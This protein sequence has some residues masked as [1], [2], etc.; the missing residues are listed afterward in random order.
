MV[1]TQTNHA[2]VAG[3]CA[4]RGATAAGVLLLALAL[5]AGG[6]LGAG[7][8]APLFTVLHCYSCDTSGDK[9][10]EEQD[11]EQSS[12]ESEA[13]DSKLERE[14]E[15]LSVAC[16]DCSVEAHATGVASCNT[17]SSTPF[18]YVWN[19]NEY[20]VDNDVLLAPGTFHATFAA[21]ASAYRQKHTFDTYLLRETP[22]V[23]EG[24]LKLA[25]KEIEPEETHLDT[26]ALTRL[27][28]PNNMLLCETPLRDD[29]QLF[30]KNELEA[31]RGVSSVAVQTGE[32]GQSAVG[33]QVTS[34]HEVTLE[35]GQV[36]E[37][38]GIVENAALH[39]TPYLLLRSRYRD[40]AAGR[41]EAFEEEARP[42]P[43]SNMAR[44]QGTGVRAAA[45]ALLAPF[46]W[47]ANTGTAPQ[48]APNDPAFLASH[49][50]TTA[51]AAVPA[52][53]GCGCSASNDE[54]SLV[55]EYFNP[56]DGRW[57][58]AVIVQPR[59]HH[60]VLEAVPLPAAAVN[61]A[62]GAVRVRV[63]ATK[64]HVVDILSLFVPSYVGTK[65]NV[66]ATPLSLTGATH[67]RLGAVGTLGGR[68]GAAA[69]VHLVPADTLTL[70]FSSPAPP[71]GN[72]QHAHLLTLHG[73]YTKLSPEGERLAGTWVEK[74]EEG[75]RARLREMYA[76]KD[77]HHPTRT[78]VVA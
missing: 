55:I 69:L 63:T 12:N 72:M 18:L 49:F 70:T 59:S 62:T 77:Y 78:P 66:V 23:E 73:F 34:P 37:L 7:A 9:E 11:R 38:E 35:T 65:D 30:Q 1:R 42:S 41:I 19:G 58:Q 51:H 24:A 64:R 75:D 68:A 76:L 17:N 8:L 16:Y 27:S 20:V 57:V 31:R 33:T 50:G 3:V 53:G 36:V 48:E 29:V 52:C 43:F 61:T 14:K 28:Y 26:V 74:L 54:H 4:A 25:I 71:Q 21:G 15:Q 13:M 39:N 44:M 60:A 5:E 6:L 45:L 32:G 47:F 2:P 22:V 56:A 46:M 67:S 40:W 10:A